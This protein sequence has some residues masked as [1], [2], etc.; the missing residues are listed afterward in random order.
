MGLRFV[1]GRSGSGKSTYILDEIKKEA[2]KNETTSII[3]LVP[4]QYTFEV[5]N[6]VSKLFLGKEKDKYL[7]V[8]VL[9]FK[10]LSNIVFS[11]V[12]GLTDVNINSSGKAMMVYRA[13]EDVSEEL[14]VFSKSKSQSGFV[15]S[16]TDMISEM[17]QYNISPEMLENISGELD[18]ETLSLKL[19]D[20]SKIY[21]SFEGKLHEN[22]V[23]AQD[24][25]TSLASKIELS[26][27][28]DGACVYIDEFTGFTPNQYNV[29]KSILNKSKSVNISLT[30]DDINYIGYRKSDMFSRTKFTY[31]KLTQLCNEEGIKILPQVNLNT[32][33]IKRFEKVKELQHLERFYNAYPYK[34]Y[35]NQTENI[36]IK[37]FN[38][39]YSEVEEIAREIVHLVRDK[40]VRYRDITIAT[41]DLSRYDFLV[42]SIFN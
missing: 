11:Q 7:R 42:H 27:Y 36:K 18:N 17:K 5:E 2:Q 8:R 3:L 26:S 20:I 9:S 22:Y 4:E 32:G 25:L 21:N 23:D 24:M 34:I 28:L 15:S 13:I 10:T 29:I 16:I 41:R 30:V 12:G 39:L 6:R 38:N 19:K 1:L 40:N 33:V 31:S 37:E 35:S 14:N